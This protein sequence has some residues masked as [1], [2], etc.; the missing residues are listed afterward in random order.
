MLYSA[1]GLGWKWIQLLL[2]IIMLFSPCTHQPVINPRYLKANLS[3]QTA[4]ETL[5]P[6]PK[7]AS[8]IS[9]VSLPLKRTD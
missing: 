7:V 6:L 9:S 2:I 3:M 1:V 8:I 5:F 4:L